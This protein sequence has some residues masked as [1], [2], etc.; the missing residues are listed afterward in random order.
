MRLNIRDLSTDIQ[1][2]LEL[3]D[4]LVETIEGLRLYKAAADLADFFEEYLADLDELIKHLAPGT[5]APATA[6]QALALDALLASVRIEIPQD[7]ADR[8]PGGCT[9]PLP[10]DIPGRGPK[11]PQKASR[12]AMAAGRRN[13]AAAAS[14]SVSAAAASRRP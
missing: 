8:L 11:R 13:A 1:T 7:S 9:F 12:Q 10:A 6:D 5:A 14:G 3:R 2:L 4:N